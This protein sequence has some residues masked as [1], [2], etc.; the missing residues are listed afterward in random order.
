M[1]IL[2]YRNQHGFLD[3]SHPWTASAEVAIG[4]TALVSTDFYVYIFPPTF[5]VMHRSILRFTGL[6]GKQGYE[7]RESRDS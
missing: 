3:I 4:T 5:Q 2:G 7:M 6:A 1:S